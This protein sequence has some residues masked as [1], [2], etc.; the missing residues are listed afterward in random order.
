M[1]LFAYGTLIDRALLE[2]KIGHAAGGSPQPA[3]LDGYRRTHDARRGYP[4]VTP[5]ESQCVIG[6]VWSGLSDDDMRLLDAYEGVDA[7]PPEY[8][9]RQL[10]VRITGSDEA[11]TVEVY[12]GNPAAFAGE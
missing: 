8:W 3:R 4:W 2:S 11:I 6:V 12:V 7:D 10:Q 5:D 1:Q 9:R